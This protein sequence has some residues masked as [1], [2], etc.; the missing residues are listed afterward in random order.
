LEVYEAEI[1]LIFE[2]LNDGY[3]FMQD[4]ASIYRAHSVQAWFMAYSITQIGNW[5]VYS[6]DLNPIKHI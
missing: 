4:N 3:L 6:L 2:E 5:P 1:A